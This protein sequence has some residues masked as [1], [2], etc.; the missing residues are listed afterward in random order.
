VIN[1]ETHI[2][3]PETS[4][5]GISHDICDLLLLLAPKRMAYAAIENQQNQ[6]VELKTFQIR[7]QQSEDLPSEEYHR[8]IDQES[9]LQQSYANVKVS[10]HNRWMTLIPADYFQADQIS[11]F[12]RFNLEKDQS[13]VLG[14]YD[15]LAS[16]DAYNAYGVPQSVASLVEEYVAEH[17]YRHASSCFLNL[18]MHEQKTEKGEQVFVNIESRHLDIIIVQDGQFRFFNQFHFRTTKDFIYYLLLTCDEFDLDRDQ[19][20]LTLSGDIEAD[21]AIYQIA[22]KYIRH[23]ALADRP[24]ILTYPQEMQQ[25][26]AHYHQNLLSLALCG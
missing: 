19:L 10:I 15:Q 4:L 25:L 14:H 7:S 21:S 9:A 24:Q 12:L 13:A 3:S 2:A 17:H 20:Q 16:I 1:T 8:L 18:V 23:I 5:T 6:L 26:P 11:S 22:Y